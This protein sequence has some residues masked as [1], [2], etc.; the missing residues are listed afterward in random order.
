MKLIL[1]QVC[2][3]VG[4]VSHFI[5]STGSGFHKTIDKRVWLSLLPL[6]FICWARVS[7]LFLK[8]TGFQFASSQNFEN[9]QFSFAGSHKL[10]ITY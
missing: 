8:K 4:R 6:N 10:R 5:V 9:N 1:P 3:S 2:T 7:Q